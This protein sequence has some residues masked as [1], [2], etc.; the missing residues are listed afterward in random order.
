MI[1]IRV[2]RQ[3]CSHILE[4]IKPET[5]MKLYEPQVL[6]VRTCGTYCNICVYIIHCCKALLSTHAS[7][8]KSH[9]TTT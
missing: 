2:R 5:G 8:R 3:H 7:S 4:V 6:K 1:L 9:L